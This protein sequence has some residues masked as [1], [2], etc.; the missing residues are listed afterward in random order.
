MAKIDPK[1]AAQQKAEQAK[2]EAEEKK[3]AAAEKAKL[4]L[5]QK[6]DA[7]RKVKQ[8]KELKLA[9][10]KKAKED[11]IK[12]KKSGTTKQMAPTPV[13]SSSSSSSSSSLPKNLVSVITKSKGNVSKVEEAIKQFNDGKIQN[14]QF[15]KAVIG[16]MGSTD[17][18]VGVLPDIIGALPRGDRKSKLNQYYQQQL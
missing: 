11:E 8:E 16:A 1:K 9:A 10:E 5:Q 17:A 7:E 12:K 3:L 13:S 14:E 15:C 2:K 4:E 18:A 6:K